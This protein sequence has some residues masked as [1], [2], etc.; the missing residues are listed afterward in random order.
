M[1]QKE[2]YEGYDSLA[3][4]VIELAVE[5]YKREY[6]KSL[7]NGYRT[8]ALKRLDTF[9]SS[10]WCDILSFGHGIRIRDKV[11]EEVKEKYEKRQSLGREKRAGKV[12]TYNGVSKTLKEWATDIGISTDTLS[13]RL[14]YGWTLEEALT[15][16]RRRYR[17]DG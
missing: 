8:K 1:C 14:K 12:L 3:V 11:R 10:E 9:F 4:A 16:K 17:D 15:I 2:R 5:D 7:V 6:Y 13:A